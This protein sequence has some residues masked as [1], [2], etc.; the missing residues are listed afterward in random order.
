[1]KILLLTQNNTVA[2]LV[3]LTIDTI[4]DANIDIV[5]DIDDIS[6]DCY[7]VLLVDDTFLNLN[8]VLKEIKDKLIIKETILLGKGDAVVKEAV[9]KVL[10]KPFLPRELEALLEKSSIL[11]SE[12]EEEI[13]NLYEEPKSFALDAKE[14]MQI[15]ALMDDDMFEKRKEVEEDSLNKESIDFERFI[16]MINSLKSKKLK[17]LLKGAKIKIEI[18]FPKENE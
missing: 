14:I 17:K 10:N 12:A 13:E 1:M 15:K 6:K 11:E 3:K 9:D 4:E 18:E 5:S 7:D 8:E 2:S 16:E